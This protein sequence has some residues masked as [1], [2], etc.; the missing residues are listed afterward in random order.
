MHSWVRIQERKRGHRRLRPAA[1]AAS[2]PSRETP[3][4]APRSR[5][6]RLRSGGSTPWVCEHLG[7]ELAE[8]DRLAVGDEVGL[9][10]PALLG[11]E[12]QSL[13]DV[14]DVG[15]VGDVARRRR[16]RRICPPRPSPPSPAAASCRPCPR[17]SG[18]ARRRSRSRRGSRRGPPARPSPW[19]PG[20]GP[21][22]RAA[23]AP[24]RRRGPAAR[25]P[26]A[27][28]RCRSGRSGARRPPRRRRARC[29]CPSTLPRSKSSHGPHSP[30]WAARWKATL[31]A[32]GARRRASA[33]AEVAADRLGAERR[34]PL[35]ADA[36][37]RASARTGR[38]SRD[39]A[40]DQP[41]ADEARAAGHESRRASSRRS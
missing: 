41:A 12:Q 19:S 35:A 1:A 38:P 13:D 24:S 18:A 9:A 5:P 26:S 37:E 20:R 6:G 29:G 15:R 40:L 32:R 23:A 2:R 4:A 25:R 31:A 17:R 22:S 14:V 33:V 27:P 34:R 21:A 11:G 36:S 3:P 8:D 39:Q 10:R 30:R 28:P 16:P 7:D